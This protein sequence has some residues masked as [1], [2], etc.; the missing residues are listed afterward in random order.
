ML[1]HGG[2]GEDGGKGVGLVESPVVDEA[3]VTGCALKVEAEKD[4]S[5]VL[6]RLHLYNLRGIYRASPFYAVDEGG[7]LAGIGAEQLFGELVVWF[8]RL[9]RSL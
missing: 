9:Q 4:L 5:D 2:V 1:L 3:V 7:L 8:V 6:G